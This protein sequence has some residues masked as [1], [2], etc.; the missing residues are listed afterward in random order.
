[1]KKLNFYLFIRRSALILTL[2][3]LHLACTSM[4]TEAKMKAPGGKG[5]ITKTLVKN[6]RALEAC[7]PES[8]SLNSGE[9]LKMIVRFEV[10]E[11][12]RVSG[13][14]IERMSSPDPDF[15]ACIMKKIQRMKFDEPEFGEPLRVRYPLIFEQGGS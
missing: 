1:M 13:L 8:I 2:P 7:I 9:G 10:Q 6:Q 11:T 14:E 12:G 3:L 4:G 5:P 15:G